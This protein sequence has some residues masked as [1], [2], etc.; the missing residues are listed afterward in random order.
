[1]H[2]IISELISVS[3][4]AV[5]T[6]LP[7]S[8]SLKRHRENEGADGA[9]PPDFTIVSF[10][11]NSTAGSTFISEPCSS[12]FTE[13]SLDTLGL[14]SSLPP[15]S[16]FDWN[17]FAHGLPLRTEDLGR[18]PVHFMT[19]VESGTSRGFD[20]QGARL[21]GQYSDPNPDSVPPYL[22]HSA[23]G[24]SGNFSWLKYY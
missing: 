24:M 20:T 11:A 6:E 17:Q 8:I 1:M 18:L 23:Y 14:P 12:E 9:P 3:N 10:P 5:P 4:T 13:V 22:Q 15:V 19:G 7:P 16:D 2:D 21:Y